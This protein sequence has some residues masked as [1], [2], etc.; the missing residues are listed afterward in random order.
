MSQFDINLTF[1]D[2]EVEKYGKKFATAFANNLKALNITGTDKKPNGK[3]TSGSGGNTV[4]NFDKKGSRA[5]VFN[6][7]FGLFKTN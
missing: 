3:G 4:D 7:D 2:S 1:K 5:C 6:K